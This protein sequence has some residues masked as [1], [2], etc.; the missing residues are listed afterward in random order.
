MKKYPRLV[1]WSYYSGMGLFATKNTKEQLTEVYITDPKGEEILKGGQ[2]ACL[3]NTKL[4]AGPEDPYFEVRRKTG[5]TTR[6]RKHG[7]MMYNIRD[8]YPELENKL[9]GFKS[10]IKEY[11]DYIYLDLSFIDNYSNSMVK[12]NPNFISENFYKKEC[13]DVDFILKLIS[14]RPRDLMGNNIIRKYEAS[15]LPEFL[16]E[17]Q[18]KFPDLYH[19]ALKES[20]WLKKNKNELSLAGKDAKVWSLN[21]GRVKVYDGLNRYTYYWDGEKLTNEKDLGNGVLV[22]QTIKPPKDMVVEILDSETVN[23]DIELVE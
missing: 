2:V 5:Y 23:P 21:K 17:L 10:K 12:D 15:E 18:I 7:D 19:E 13:F 16:A 14:Y 11:G 6:A 4:F 1:S 9:T 3:N 22:Q 20:E 8:K